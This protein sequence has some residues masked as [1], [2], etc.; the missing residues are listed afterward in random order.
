MCA[1]VA[2]S[3][4][5]SIEAITVAGPCYHYVGPFYSSYCD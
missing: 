4:G 2:V 3:D 1:Y 5:L